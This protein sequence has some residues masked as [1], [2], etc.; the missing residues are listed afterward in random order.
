MSSTGILTLLEDMPE[1]RESLHLLEHTEVA[2]GL[3]G[4]SGSLKAALVCTMSQVHG[5]PVLVV[6]PT[7]QQAELLAEDAATLAGTD[8]V[9]VLPPLD[10]LPYDVYAHSPEIASRRLALLDRT[11]RDRRVVMVAPLAAFLRKMM[12]ADTFFG[13]S[14]HVKVGDISDPEELA[15]RLLGLGYKRQPMTEVPGVFSTRGGIIDIY[16]PSQHSPIRLEFFDTDIVSIREFDPSTQRTVREIKDA[17]IPPARET[18]C[19]ADTKAAACRIERDLD[20][21][22]ARLASGK[23][24]EEAERFCA[25][26]R[27]NLDQLMHDIPFEGMEQYVAYL[28]EKPETVL[29][30]MDPSTILVIDDFARITEAHSTLCKE[31]V[32]LVAPLIEQGRL[33]PLQAD[34]YFSLDSVIRQDRSRVYISSLQK[35]FPERVQEIAIASRSGRS[36]MGQW[37]E[38]V[39]D[40]RIKLK[41]GTRVVVYVSSSERGQRIAA[42]LREEEIPARAVQDLPDVPPRNEVRV[43]PGVLEAGFEVP[44][45][46]LSVFTDKEIF[47]RVKRRP[48]LKRRDGLR[49]SSIEDLKIGDYVVHVNHGIGKYLGIKV[50]EID[51]SQR[52]YLFIKYAGADALY[53]P[54]DQIDLIQ[55]YVGGEGKEPK[56]SRLGG[57][58]WQ[59]TKRKVKESLRD[60]ALQLVQLY[61][62]RQAIP[63]YSFACDPPWQREFEDLFKYEETPDQLTAAEEIKRDMEEPRPMDRLLCG[64][65]GYGKTEVALRAAF[66]AVM[67]GK[68]V[69]ILVPTTILAQ[70]HYNTCK[71][72][73][74]PYPV[75]IE[76]LSRFKS[77]A[78]QHSILKDL[79]EGRIDIII[80]THR[81]LGPDVEFHDLGLLI[82]DEEQ[83]FGVAHKERLKRLKSTV[84]VLTLT[85]TPIPRTLHMALAGIRDMSVIETPPE[86]RFPVQTYV[87]EYEEDFIKEA[88]MR[89]INRGGQ[90]YY[91]YNRV[92]NIDRVASRLQEILPGVRV[93][94]AHGQ[95]KE[96]RLEQVMMDFLDGVY[97]VLVC[98]TIIESGLDISNV[99]TLI[100]ENADQLGLAQLYQLRGRVGR[101]NRLAFAYF[102]YR[103]DKVLNE[104]AEKRLE[105]IREFTEL[106]SGIRIAMKD[107]EIRGAGNLL[108]PEQHGFIASVGFD[109]YCKMLEEAVAEIQGVKKV[110]KPQATIEIKRDSFIPA[111]YIPDVRQKLDIYK[112]L[113][114][115]ESLTDVDDVEEEIWDRFGEP[116]ESVQNLLSIVRLKI[117]ASGLG[118][119][120]I[121]EKRLRVMFTWARPIAAHVETLNVLNRKF[122]GRVYFASPRRKELVVKMLDES[123]DVLLLSH[124]V[125]DL[126]ASH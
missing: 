12:P 77:G 119:L 6:T 34:P 49:L 36:Y 101:S 94:V 20:R 92:Q 10:L 48:R 63:G 126:L 25:R 39:N 99:N 44:G 90:V 16:P 114:L 59:R 17:R 64:D 93:V 111:D 78:Q 67:E 109:L 62:E 22:T 117:K 82:I 61:A 97:D 32:S 103:R 81:L 3:T 11:V 15:S 8:N 73:F 100:V 71:E 123:E 4:V 18:L 38:F 76:V 30:W 83:R 104:A 96:D 47:G 112:K 2:I 40:L 102:T 87:V 118:L 80:G 5:R 42:S 89:E 51:G 91:V 57:R 21:L 68:Q 69:A 53:V 98:T 58:D 45:A 110:S 46:G 113:S 105:A 116:P 54:T 7:W 28:Y 14:F 124:Q 115:C 1:I 13:R 72:R 65:V 35:R 70:Q 125:L 79:R 29:D 19:P 84:D 86:E 60:M 50:L 26:V 43:I 9:A 88:I 37:R 33:L 108:G 52:D 23:R 95:M 75:N 66:K 55:K 27:S 121:T 74:E 106:G 85:A 24:N 120:S 122:K 107:L 41:H 31:T 56:I